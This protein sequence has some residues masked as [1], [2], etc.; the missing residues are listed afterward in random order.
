M[1]VL[2]STINI[3]LHLVGE[4]EADPVREAVR[5]DGR[6]RPSLAETL[7]QSIEHTTT[8]VFEKHEVTSCDLSLS[9]DLVKGRVPGV[10]RERIQASLD[11]EGEP[12]ELA[13]VDEA[14][15]PPERAQIAAAVEEAVLG[16]L[17][18]YGVE[19]DVSVTISV[20][21]VQFR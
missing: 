1:P 15:G 17:D 21:P 14:V 6:V 18:Q 11:A 3:D 13:S 4:T 8:Q 10:P 5:R 9:L 2:E 20:T 7:E 19:D 16:H 12:P